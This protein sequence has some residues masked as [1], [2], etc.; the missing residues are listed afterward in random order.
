MN[1][2]LFSILMLLPLLAFAQLSDY[3]YCINNPAIGEFNIAKIHLPTGELTNFDDIANSVSSFYSTCVNMDTED[4]YFCDGYSLTVFD[5]QTEQLEPSIDFPL[6]A[7]SSYHQIQ[8]NP[9][10]SSLYGIVAQNNFTAFSI[11]R[12]DFETFE[13]ENISNLPSDFYSCGNCISGIDPINNL[14]VSDHGGISGIDLATGAE[15]YSAYPINPSGFAFGHIS[16]KCST[17]EFFGTLAN[18]NQE[19]KQLGVVSQETGV[20]TS[21]SDVT[22]SVGFWKPYGGGNVIDQETGIYYY[23]GADGYLIG[24]NTVTGALAYSEDVSSG[25]IFFLQHFSQCA[26]PEA[27]NIAEQEGLEL[28]L[29]AYPN[30][31]DDRFIVSYEKEELIQYTLRNLLGQTLEQG[32]FLNQ[33]ELNTE[34]LSEGTYLCEFQDT[35]GNSYQVKLVKE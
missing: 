35:K 10:D 32:Q 3:V 23:S 16:Y 5:T 25:E 31:V 8:Y 26:C 21:I 1:K 28:N 19:T 14:F 22:W 4:F 7:N 12:F 20:V 34:S 29:D 13:F 30:P 27:V 24:A 11:Q 33:L 2:P 9:C 18:L 6:A 15:A 17:Q